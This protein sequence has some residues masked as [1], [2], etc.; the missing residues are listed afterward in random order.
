MK[1]LHKSSVHQ[2]ASEYGPAFALANVCANEA[3]GNISMFIPVPSMFSVQP[4]QL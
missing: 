1:V 4:V 3:V 2:I